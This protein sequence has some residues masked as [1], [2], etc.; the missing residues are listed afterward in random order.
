M[1]IRACPNCGEPGEMW[2]EEDPYYPGGPVVIGHYIECSKCTLRL[3]GEDKNEL[4]REWNK[5]PRRR[6]S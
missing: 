2:D 1:K 6:H 5:M 3:C 4:I